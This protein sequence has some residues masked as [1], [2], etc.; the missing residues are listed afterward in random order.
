MHH[1]FNQN[2]AHRR[3]VGQ[4]G[5]CGFQLVDD[6][7]AQPLRICSTD[8]NTKDT[9][10]RKT[11]LVVDTVCSW[12]NGQCQLKLNNTGGV[13]TCTKEINQGECL[14]QSALTVVSCEWHEPPYI[15]LQPTAAP[16]AFPKTFKKYCGFQ[17]DMNYTVEPFR[18]CSSIAKTATDCESKSILETVGCFWQA[19][20]CQPTKV[21]F[22]GY[23]SFKS[24]L[25]DCYSTPALAVTSS[26]AWYEVEVKSEAFCGFPYDEQ[27]WVFPPALCSFK[28]TDPV[29]CEKTGFLSA[30]IFCTWDKDRCAS[31]P[32]NSRFA[33]ACSTINGIENCYGYRGGFGNGY[34]KWF[35]PPT[36]H[37]TDSPVTLTSPSEAP[38]ITPP[39]SS[40]PTSTFYPS[41]T[42]SV[43][44]TPS[45]MP[46]AIPSSVRTIRPSPDPTNRSTP[47][48]RNPNP[49]RNPTPSPTPKPTRVPTTV[50]TSF[51]SVA[52]TAH[53]TENPTRRPIDPPKA[54]NQSSSPTV[55][56]TGSPTTIPSRVPTTA[57]TALPSLRP[58]LRPSEFPTPVP[59]K[60]PSNLPS[61]RPS[62]FPTDRPSQLPTVIP[63]FLPSFMPYEPE[64][65]KDKNGSS[66]WKIAAF[67]VAGAA[68]GG[69][70]CCGA[71]FWLSKK[72]AG[73]P[74]G[75]DAGNRLAPT[76]S[77]EQAPRSTTAIVFGNVDTPFHEYNTG[78]QEVSGS[79]SNTCTDDLDNKGD[80]GAPGIDVLSMKSNLLGEAPSKNR[81]DGVILTV[82]PPGWFW[83]RIFRYLSW[84]CE[85]ALPA[86]PLK[87][88]DENKKLIKKSIII[89]GS[90]SGWFWERVLRAI[91]SCCKSG[92]GR[93]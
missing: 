85:P 36:M 43:L 28:A 15:G 17:G 9:C 58:S 27:P 79:L 90:P 37:P 73:S 11:L 78:K 49:T 55:V 66:T 57:P 44:P 72:K 13:N 75:H 31:A 41:M 23:C 40:N 38:S 22:D 69:A 14:S 45:P 82:S 70:G 63:T 51:P 64:T 19:G 65:E 1:G 35:E 30:A 42:P 87:T 83:E 18:R 77:Q 25:V 91:L 86:T 68:V 7:W 56:P 61:V 32:S 16:S 81:V 4:V 71:C 52:P 48:P 76:F 92:S 21:G 88:H 29:E 5:Y 6:P 67:G 8:S 93:T 20:T 74:D 54:I 12:N 59:S 33:P 80:N 24:S 47:R 26:C 3:E 2:S 89:I 60:P 34:C 50:P 62:P 84:K 46:S 10:A 53:P 39:L